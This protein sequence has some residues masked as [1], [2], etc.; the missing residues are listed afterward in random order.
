MDQRTEHDSMGEVQVPAQA[1][2]GAQTQRSLEHFAI[3]GERLP[4]ALIRALGLVK[5]ACA[6]VNVEL[7]TLDPVPGDFIQRAAAEVAAG[8]LDD[9]FPLVVWQTG[10]GTQSNMNA[11]EVIANR[12]SE[13]AGQ[14]RGSYRP[15]HPNDH[16]N[17][18]QSS[19]DVFPTAIHVAAARELREALVPAVRALRDVL[20][21]KADAFKDLVKVGRTHL[22][23]AVPLTLGQEFGGWASQLEHSLERLERALEELMELPIGGTAVGTGLNAPPGF[24][25]R[26]VQALRD[27]TELPFV[28]ARNPFEA[29]AAR[30][31]CVSAHGALRT[32]AASLMKLAEDVRSLA[33]GPRC[34]LGEL[35]L[36]ANEP[37]S[38][39]MPGKVNPTQCEALIMVGMRVMGNDATVGLA[40]AGGRFQLNTC[41]PVLAHALLQSIRLLAD[42]CRSFERHCARGIGPDRA[43]IRELLERTLMTVTAL[44]PRI[45]Y[46]QAA[47]VA[48]RALGENRTLKEI[49]AEEGLLGPEEAEALL[50][51]RRMAG[52]EGPPT[53]PSPSP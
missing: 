29:L 31:A 40:G 5:Q 1:Y 19:N 37:G 50:D 2:W 25:M 18:S 30:D 20:A 52:L 7:G 21:A 6:R 32:L 3:G 12:A 13:L 35:R 49:V 43:R 15:A 48:Q 14:P 53:P 36:P 4:S 51:P 44:A 17:R 47:R 45:G 46:E 41:M 28:P 10:S 39:I 33:S 8:R 34:G 42:G 26:V 22:Q 11:N 38:S 23:D 24:G 9:Q 27:A 16:V